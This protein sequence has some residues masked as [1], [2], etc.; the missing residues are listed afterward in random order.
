VQDEAVAERIVLISYYVDGM[1]L[2][3]APEGTDISCGNEVSVESHRL[4][5]HEIRRPCILVNEGKGKVKIKP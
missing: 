5:L 4:P 2:C 3:R 1:L